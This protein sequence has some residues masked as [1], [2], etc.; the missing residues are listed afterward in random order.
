MKEDITILVN[1]CDTYE[2]TW[3][4]FFKL[5]KKIG[6]NVRMKLY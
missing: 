2:D 4:P 5:L 6:H 3:F 1:S